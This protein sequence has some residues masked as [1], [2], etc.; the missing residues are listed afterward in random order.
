MKNLA[1][2][3][4]IEFLKQTNKIRHAVEGWLKETGILKIRSTEP[5][6]LEIREDMTDDEKSAVI[7]EN[8]KLKA[9]QARKNLSSMLDVAL[10]ANAEKTF[11]VLAMMCFLTPEESKTVKASELLLNF[12]E[13]IAD[14]GV[15]GFFSLLRQSELLDF[16]N[17]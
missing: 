12:A 6:Y 16:L 5:K 10:D 3:N 2:C 14:E 8:K 4:G 9:D 11:E 7:E 13:M 1:N 17:Q 15:L